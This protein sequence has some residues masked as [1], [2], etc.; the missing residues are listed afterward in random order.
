MPCRYFT[1]LISFFFDKMNGF[2]RFF[3]FTYFYPKLDVLSL[4]LKKEKILS[5]KTVYS[6]S[7]FFFR[8]FACLFSVITSAVVI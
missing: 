3:V 7:Y 5:P 4:V 1:S 6:R 8:L 2:I